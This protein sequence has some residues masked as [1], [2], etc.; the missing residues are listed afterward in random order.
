MR[1]IADAALSFGQPLDYPYM[2][3][4]YLA[5]NAIR[6][7]GIFVDGPD[8]ALGKT[9]HIFGVHDR[10]STMLRAGGGGRVAFSG[11]DVA[12]AP[13]AGTDYGDESAGALALQGRADAVVVASLP[14]CLAAGADDASRAKRLS[15]RWSV[16]Y[17]GL[18]RR[19]LHA[20]WLDGYDAVLTALARELP[21]SAASGRGESVAFI[22]AWFD[23]NEEDRLS[24]IQEL[25]GAAQALG[26]EVASVWPSGARLRDLAEAGRAGVVVSLPY[27]R[28]AA[29][30]L[31]ERTGARLL[32]MDWPLGFSASRRWI[33]Q[34]GERLGRRAQAEKHVR[35][36]EARTGPEIE[37]LARALSGVKVAVA[38]DPVALPAWCRFLTEMSAVVSLAAGVGRNRADCPLASADAGRVLER[39][40]SGLWRRELARAR[41]GGAELLVASSDAR[42]WGE[43]RGAWLEEGFPSRTRHALRPRPSLLF[44]GALAAAQAAVQALGR[45][46]P[47]PRRRGRRG[48]LLASLG[49]TQS[50]RREI[51]RLLDAAGLEIGADGG[52]VLSPPPVGLRATERFVLRTAAA[53]GRLERA[54]S[55]LG[56]E[57][58]EWVPRLE[59]AV[60]QV[61][62][63]ASVVFF[64]A[65]ALARAWKRWQAEIG[66]SVTV[67]KDERVD[68]RLWEAADADLC[69]APEMLP[70]LESLGGKSAW[71]EYPRRTDGLG[72][73]FSGAAA[74]I[75]AL[76]DAIVRV[77][78][79]RCR[80]W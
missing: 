20:D 10:R 9:E 19:H 16:P 15:K 41:E 77:R 11:F 51:A 79:E 59:P 58:R 46:S 74:L 4:A 33:M 54:R 37:R 31:C 48:D 1:G 71:F 40:T 14:M 6:D 18:P 68:P 28:A 5:V 76:A 73:G 49:A 2:V 39:P 29:R 70:G 13:T 34:L 66:M 3:G 25:R 67:L 23:R 55:F 62:C 72:L 69:V 43:D 38:F 63:G 36:C 56:L 17:W 7:L 21:L 35:R 65:P 53:A 61:L 27:G 47:P 80:S 78:E 12:H 30:A 52:R 8:C 64:G 75:E 22:G 26:L 42:L 44:D 24:D 60:S 32:E 50:D 57:L 45:Q